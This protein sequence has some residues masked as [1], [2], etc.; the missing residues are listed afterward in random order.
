DVW[1]A[2]YLHSLILDHLESG[3]TLQLRHHAVSQARRL[4]PGLHIRN[5]RTAGPGQEA[6]NHACNRCCYVYEGES[7]QQYQVSSVVTDGI[8]IGRPTCSVH[9]CTNPLPN[10]RHHYCGPHHGLSKL[11]AVVKCDKEVEEGFRTC[12]FEDHRKIEL[13]QYQKG[14]A[15]FQLKKRLE[16]VK[17]PGVDDDKELALTLEG[18]CDGKPETGNRNVQARF[19]RRWTHNEQL[20]VASCGVIL[21]RATFYGS[22]APNG[23]WTFWRRLFPTKASLPFVL[24]HD[25]N[26]RVMAMLQNDPNDHPD[27]GYFDVCALA[28]DVFHFNCKHKES[29]EACNRDCNPYKWPILQ[30]PKGNW[31]FNSSAAKQANTWFGGF[32]AIIQE[33]QVDRYEFF[34]DEMIKQRNRMIIKELKCK[35]EC[36]YLIPREELLR[37]D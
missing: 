9:D 19:G 36:P 37:E 16:R 28:V 4:Q 18:T 27:K 29:D 2:F 14:K 3:S 33:M 21:G 12:P 15:M 17:G 1:N 7:G 26:C 13:Y 6:W 11:C 35:G 32:Q 30:T 25:N 20:C 8:T 23:V 22:E 24:W 31:C 5:A 34:L 10:V